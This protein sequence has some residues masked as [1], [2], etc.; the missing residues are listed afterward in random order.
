MR[1]TN[2]TSYCAIVASTLSCLLLATVC[3]GCKRTTP[4]NEQQPQPPAEA[5]AQAS[6]AI[7]PAQ[8]PSFDRSTISDVVLHTL[9]TAREGGGVVLQGQCSGRS[10]ADVY[11]A[12][13][14]PAGKS[15][16]E[17]LKEISA[18]HQ[19][20][21]WHQ[22]RSSGVRVVD[23]K[24]QAAILK[25]RVREFRVIEDLEPDAVMSVLWRQPEV[26]AFLRRHNVVFTR[27][28]YGARKVLSPPMIV[29]MKN[30]TVAEILD[31]IAAGYHSNPPKVW[32]YQECRDQK[33]TVI[34]VRM[35]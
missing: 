24:T 25:V 34:D 1:P 8:P 9:Y 3:A 31:R 20:I 29:E 26:R 33:T 27:R 28:A 22:S 7:G 35:P 18:Q 17:S 6:A 32:I 13:P 5:P 4:E 12:S 11:T 16:Q 10:I 14:P 21:E 15:L 2:S 23:R 19:N 30:R